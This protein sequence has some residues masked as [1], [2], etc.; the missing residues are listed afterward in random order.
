MKKIGAA[1]IAV[2][3]MIGTARTVGAEKLPDWEGS[4]TLMMYYDGL[5]LNGGSLRICRVGE[6]REAGGSIHFEPLPELRYAGSFPEDL[7]NRDLAKE[8]AALAEDLPWESVPVREG[9]AEFTQLEPGLWLV[10]QPEADAVAGFAPISP[11]L[12][13]V[14]QLENGRWEHHAAASPKVSPVGE[15]PQ[16]GLMIWPVPVLALGGLILLAAG[17]ILC[18]GGKKRRR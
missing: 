13:S 18:S 3:L 15:L 1:L 8:L 5:P 10:M 17:W 6:I 4:I 2:L 9:R 7:S 12:L 11:F 14:P 16:T